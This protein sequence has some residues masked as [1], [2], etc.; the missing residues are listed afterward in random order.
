VDVHPLIPPLV[1]FVIAFVGT[2]AGVTG[3]FLLLPFQ[4]SVLGFTNPSVSAT[5]L[6]YNIASTPG[7]IWRYRKDGRIDAGLTKLILLG[8]LPGVLVGAYIRIEYLPDSDSFR[9][10]VGLLLLPLGIKLIFDAIRKTREREA[11]DPASAP[12]I[13]MALAVG[14]AGGIY[15]IGGSAIIAPFLVGIF[16]LATSRVVGA[17]LIGTFFTSIVGVVT[18]YVLSAEP[19]WALGLLFGVGGIVGSYAGA[20]FRRHLP[21][22]AIKALLGVLAGTLGVFYL[23]G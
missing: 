17:A 9:R 23:L 18:F 1:A 6:V 15:G 16:G 5:N 10:L 12:V 13:A 2:P 14:V 21:E 19:D 11:A 4:V 22:A 20:R 8:T 3:A 7:G